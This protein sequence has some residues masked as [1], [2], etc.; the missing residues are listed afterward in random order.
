MINQITQIT[1]SLHDVWM[2]TMQ[3]RNIWDGDD[4][5]Q[6]SL[7]TFVAELNSDQSTD[8]ESTMILGAA[9]GILR[10]KVFAV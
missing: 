7:I 9:D 4:S 5:E 8:F 3:S 2:L 1:I 10:P 6:E